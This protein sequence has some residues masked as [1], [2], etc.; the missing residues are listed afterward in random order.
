MTANALWIF[1]YGSL[2]WNPGFAYEERRLARLDGF[3]RAF[4]M[5]SVHY[6]G[7]PE[8]PGLVLALEAQDGAS[9]EGVGFRVSD[10]NA[11]G[12]LAYLRARE[13][14]SDAY[15]EQIHPINFTD[16]PSAPA[17]CYVIDPAHVQYCGGLPLHEQAAMIARAVGS[18]GAND[19][20]L[21]NTLEHLREIGIHDP[22]LEKLA[23][24]IKVAA[25]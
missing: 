5:A 21:F 9:C 13:L 23:H 17:I 4:S 7:T 20:Y 3:N 14:I 15:L 11:A 10:E 12:V 18:A 2:L 25:P 16:G 1:G 8:T 19:A 6:R 24:L 22:E